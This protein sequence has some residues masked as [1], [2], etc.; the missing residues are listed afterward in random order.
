V[1]GRH[2]GRQVAQREQPGLEDLPAVEHE[3]VGAAGQRRRV[4]GLDAVPVT[5]AELQQRPDRD[6]QAGLL[7]DLADD[8]LRERLAVLGEPAREPPLRDGGPEPVPQ[9]QHPPVGGADDPGHPDAEPRVQMPG[10]PGPQRSGGAPET[11]ERAR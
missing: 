3:T 5:G 7:A 10:Q 4:V 8:R 9:Q 11:R 6:G 2:R 1:H